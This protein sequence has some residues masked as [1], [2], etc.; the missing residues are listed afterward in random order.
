MSESTF[1]PSSRLRRIRVSASLAAAQRARELRESGRTIVDFT[2]GEP[3]FDTPQHVKDAAIAAIAAGE[4]KY[5]PVNG[6]SALRDAI[7]FRT[8]RSSG[9]RYSDAEIA[10]GGG[11][12]QLIYLAFSATLDEGDEVIIPA[13]Y[14]VSYP[15]MVLVN[16][17][18]PVPVATDAENG[19]KLT[20]ESLRAAIT[21][22][23]R[24]LVLNA[25]G[26]PSGVV[27][28]RAELEALAAVLE[29]F[30]QVWVLSDEIYAEIV[31]TSEP[32]VG[33]A[34]AAPRLRD[35]ILTI[36]GVSKAY[37][38]TGWR[39]GYAVGDARLVAAIN[40]LQ[41]QSSSCPSSISQAAAAAALTG[42]QSFVA[43][44]LAAYR[45][46]RDR[47]VAILEKVEGLRPSVPQG[48]FY[49]FVGCQGLIGKRTPAGD[50]LTDDVDV[51]LYLLE[52]AG[53]AVIQGSAYG[54]EPFFRISFATGLEEI[55]RG[56]AAIA[57]AVAALS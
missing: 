10:V 3:D 49:L 15:D 53:V 19:Y 51:T 55:E 26:N 48:A 29:E 24:W 46:R 35:R 14:W 40:T 31:Y 23:T 18:T 34:E 8:L 17:G 43:E 20:P 57:E 54:S 4:T 45:R 21:P 27:Y 16:D 42:D 7:R 13:P 11:G 41:S 9:I 47:A 33:F 12:K 37:A 25:P 2:A 5:T 32:Y 50:V 44:C 36:N 30:P 6:T 56:T 22:R 52:A 28:S 38:M 1:S 39:L